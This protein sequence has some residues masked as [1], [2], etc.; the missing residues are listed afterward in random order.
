[1]NWV[2]RKPVIILSSVSSAETKDDTQKKKHA[3]STE[4]KSVPD[5]I[6]IY[7]KAMP[8]VDLNDQKKFGRS[9]AQRRIKKFHRTI[10]NHLMDT[11]LINSY[12]YWERAPVNKDKNIT[13]ADFRDALA[14]QLFAKY[15]SHNDVQVSSEAASI[16]EPLLEEYNRSHIAIIHPKRQACQYCQDNPE[17]A[18]KKKRR[19]SKTITPPA[20]EILNDP[21]TEA[22][23]P[24]DDHAESAESKSS[25]VAPNRIKTYLNMEFDASTA[26]PSQI[27]KHFELLANPPASPKTS[28]SVVPN[29]SPEGAYKKNPGV[30][31]GPPPKKTLADLP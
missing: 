6:G 3:N 29:S 23:G 4:T 16:D 28:W 8:G 7:I 17:Q 5:C 1:M 11:T 14:A 27:R 10:F 31:K 30:K 25:K 2:D 22:I 20:L 26:S 13:H 18:N 15:C 12:V 24:N 9:V 19:L 21:D